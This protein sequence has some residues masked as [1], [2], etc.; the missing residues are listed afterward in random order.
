MKNMCFFVLYTWDNSNPMLI[1]YT[2]PLCC[3]GLVHTFSNV[4]GFLQKVVTDS[5]VKT[6]VMVFLHF[7]EENPVVKCH[8][9]WKWANLHQ[10]VSQSHVFMEKFLWVARDNHRFQPGF[11]VSS[12]L[13]KLKLKMSILIFLQLAVTVAK[14]RRQITT[15]PL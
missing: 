3:L 12:H 9:L 14:V 7:S 5:C 1:Q 13:R 10:C 6:C 11:Q 4:L 2:K 15:K 8:K